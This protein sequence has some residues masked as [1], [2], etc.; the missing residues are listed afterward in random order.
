MEC[1]RE[2][3]QERGGRAR[4]WCKD[5]VGGA[6]RGSYGIMMGE[7]RWVNMGVLWQGDG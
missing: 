7:K 6:E 2:D 4:N 5:S 1:I 3:M